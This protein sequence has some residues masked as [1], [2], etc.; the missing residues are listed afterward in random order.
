MPGK[1]HSPL[2]AH[3]F[4]LFHALCAAAAAA[5]HACT[6][7]YTRSCTP[8]YSLS[9][10]IYISRVVVVGQIFTRGIRNRGER[11]REREKERQK[12]LLR[13]SY[14]PF[15]ILGEAPFCPLASR[16]HPAEWLSASLHPV[17]RGLLWVCFAR[18]LLEVVPC[19]RV[20]RF[21]SI[22][23]TTREVFMWII[24]IILKGD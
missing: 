17:L 8:H 2:Y 24:C 21:I 3:A 5:T 23:K 4:P 7:S 11:E 14:V 19:T 12:E 22:R 20:N 13:F 10:I 9:A 18:W 6:R 16:R 1:G 15:N